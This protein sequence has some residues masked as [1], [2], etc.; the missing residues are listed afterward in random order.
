MAKSKAAKA[1]PR[2]GRV[3]D[4]VRVPRGPVDLSAFDTTAT[5]GFDGD[6]EAGKVALAD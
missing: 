1:R 3:S 4:M 2:D 6:K 5:P